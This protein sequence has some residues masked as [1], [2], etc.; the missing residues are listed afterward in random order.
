MASNAAKKLSGS[1]NPVAQTRFGV[2]FRANNDKTC[3]LT[4]LQ[5]EG[6]CG[7]PQFAMR[8]R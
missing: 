2:E 8:L 5:T 7:V 4:P 1:K 3:R 6:A